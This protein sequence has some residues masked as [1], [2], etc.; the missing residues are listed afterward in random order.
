VGKAACSFKEADVMRAVKAVCKAGQTVA[1]VR[2]NRDGGF[3]VVVGRPVE[4]NGQASV[5]TSE[6]GE[7]DNIQ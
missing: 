2:F 1:G 3:T 7:W 5:N 6:A 4:T